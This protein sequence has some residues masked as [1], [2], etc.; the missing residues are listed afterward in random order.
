M[1]IRIAFRSLFFKLILGFLVVIILLISTNLVSMYVLKEKM[2]SEVLKYNASNM[3]DTVSRFEKQWDDMLQL[4]LSEILASKPVMSI[5]RDPVFNYYQGKQ[6]QLL[7]A[8]KAL[9]QQFEYISKIAVVFTK[10]QMA[11]DSISVKTLDDMFTYYITNEDYDALFWKQLATAD[12]YYL[13]PAKKF[14][15]YRSNELVQSQREL[16]PMIVKNQLYP[17]MFSVIFLD[18]QKMLQAFHSSINERFIMLN[19]NQEVIYSTYSYDPQLIE[20]LSSNQSYMKHGEDYYFYYTDEQSGITYINIVPDAFISSEISKLNIFIVSIIIISLIIGIFTS[21]FLSMKVHQPVRRIL[22]S[23]E[24]QDPLS[25]KD[26]HIDEF[27][28]IGQKLREIHKQNQNIYK[29]L[30]D[31]QPLLKSYAYANK[32]KKIYHDFASV[33]DLKDRDKP[34]FFVVFDFKYQQDFLNEINQDEAK[35]IYYYRAFIDRELTQWSEQSMTFQFEPQQVVS[36]LFLEPDLQHNADSVLLYL[37]AIFDVDQSFCMATIAVSQ[38]YYQSNELP[39]AYEE[40]RWLI[41]TRRL[42]RETQILRVE[43]SKRQRPDVS[44]SFK[45]EQELHGFLRAANMA[46]VRQWICQLMHHMWRREA[47]AVQFHELAQM[48]VQRI[49]QGLLGNGV[50]TGELQQLEQELE[51][52]TT[53]EHYEQFFERYLAFADVQLA[54]KKEEHDPILS[55]MIPYMEEH[56]AKDLSLDILADHLQLSSGYLSAY[57]KKKSGMNF[58]DYLNQVRMEKAKEMLENT[59]LK[60]QEVGEKVGYISANSFYRMFKKWTGMTPGDYRKQAQDKE[61]L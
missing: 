60:V 2:H 44:Y 17:E 10:Y 48:M 21:V 45:Q 42:G 49:K 25:I 1:K 34:F 15:T 29:N 18:A 4:T 22:H 39:Q 9:T 26:G 53:L 47:Y 8:E 19:S 35:A 31:Q 14:H 7:L 55:V 41:H 27:N 16:I 33:I 58:I 13:Y 61:E 56:Y 36:L 23:I 24:R 20:Q 40:A 38:V 54:L 3:K 50:E 37:K 12:L 32:I 6:L 57:F 51:F 46:G 59:G 5:Y 11:I 28:L 30:E 43:K 52:C